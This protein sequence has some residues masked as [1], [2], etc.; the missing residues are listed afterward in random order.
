MHEK[1]HPRTH[2]RSIAPARITLSSPLPQG[3][4]VVRIIDHDGITGDSIA[5]CLRELS[6]CVPCDAHADRIVVRAVTYDEVRIYLSP[7]RAR[8]GDEWAAIGPAGPRGVTPEPR[9]VRDQLPTWLYLTKPRGDGPQ[10]AGWTLEECRRGLVVLSPEPEAAE[11][12]LV[13]VDH[14]IPGTW[15]VY[16]ERIGAPTTD[17][18]KHYSARIH[19]V[20]RVTLPDVD[21]PARDRALAWVGLGYGLI[22]EATSAPTLVELAQLAAGVKIRAFELT[23]VLAS[24]APSRDLIDDL[25]AEGLVVL[26]DGLLQPTS[27]GQV[28]LTALVRGGRRVR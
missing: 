1:S 19:R 12:Q 25:V 5:A 28:R 4:Y 13:L 3:A 6:R 24:H 9:E 20:S 27:L 11:R 2:S 26:R 14:G 18:A 21:A 8:L 7:E 23:D 15:L 16:D 10:V 17:G 22:P